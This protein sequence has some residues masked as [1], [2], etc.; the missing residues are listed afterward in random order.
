MVQSNDKD[1]FIQTRQCSTCKRDNGVGGPCLWFASSRRGLELEEALPHALVHLHD[2]CHV[3]CSRET[4]STQ[5]K[6]S[7]A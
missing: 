3:T 6:L 7:L 1:R 2:R 4:G 5:W